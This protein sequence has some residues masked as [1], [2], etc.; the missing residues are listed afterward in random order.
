MPVTKTDEEL[1]IALRS[2]ASNLDRP[3]TRNEMESHGE[4]SATPYYRAF[5]SW[6]DALKAAGLEP[7]YRQAITD[8]ELITELQALADELGRPPRQSDMKEQGRYS[9]TTYRRRF[10]SWLDARETA[11]LSGQETKPASRH[12]RLDLLTGLHLLASQL[13]RPPSQNDMDDR[14]L[15]SSSVYYSCFGSWTTALEEAGLQ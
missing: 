1:I 11:G 3:P 6:P 4:F 7:R 12:S 13:G 9:P 5:G 8:E 10:G 14:G 2:L 15:Y